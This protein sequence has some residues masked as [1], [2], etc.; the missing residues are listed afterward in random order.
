[1]QN[2]AEARVACQLSVPWVDLKNP[3]AGS[4]GCPDRNT[5]IEVATVIDEFKQNRNSQSAISSSVAL[6]ELAELVWKDV[7]DIQSMFDVCKV[8]LA[9]LSVADIEKH[10][11]AEMRS[12]FSSGRCALGA[13]AD[14]ARARS[15]ELESVIRLT[16]DLGGRYVLIDTFVKDG[17][18]LFHW[19]SV[20]QL[21]DLQKLARSLD[22]VLVVAGS[23]KQSD[24]P[25]LEE[26]SPSVMGVRGSVCEDTK[27][28]ESGLSSLQVQKWMEWSA[29]ARRR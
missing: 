6:G 16:R 10:L 12:V 7:S 21:C 20:E 1:M 25:V 4:L 19:L 5:A 18:G 26:L 28:R 3:K 14:S 29:S 8:G 23:L 17:Q 15:P 27:S 2:A 11:N 13:Y 9:G 24:W 22:I